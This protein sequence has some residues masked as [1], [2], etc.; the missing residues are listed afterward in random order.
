MLQIMCTL[1]EK[2]CFHVQSSLQKQKSMFRLIT[3]RT[4]NHDIRRKSLFA[5]LHDKGV[6]DDWNIEQIKIGYSFSRPTLNHRQQA[7]SRWYDVFWYSPEPDPE[8]GVDWPPH[9]RSERCLTALVTEVWLGQPSLARGEDCSCGGRG[10][11]ASNSGNCPQPW[12]G[13]GYPRPIMHLLSDLEDGKDNKDI[14]ELGTINIHSKV[15]YR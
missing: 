8:L 5:Y 7:V 15:Q 1:A 13:P 11:N 6:L 12:P 4:W 2:L 9:C 10:L 14:D 3:R